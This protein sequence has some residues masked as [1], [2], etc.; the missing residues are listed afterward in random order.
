MSPRPLKRVERIT[1]DRA[2]SLRHNPTKPEHLLWS[3]L[4]GRQLDGLK[5]RRQHPIE[6]YILDFYCAEEG[7]VVELDG[8]SHNRTIDY[9]RQRSERL[10][11]LGLTVVRVTNDDVVSNLDGVAEMI[12]RVVRL[13]RL[14]R[15]ESLP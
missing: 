2:I 13:Q 9:D 10:E 1:H 11:R 14:T 5:F 8:E 15:R 6:P 7:L 4:R 3:V 12:L